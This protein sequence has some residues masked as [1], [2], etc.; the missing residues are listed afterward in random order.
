MPTK[1]SAVTSFKSLEQQVDDLR[2]KLKDD[3]GMDMDELCENLKCYPRTAHGLVQ[4]KGWAI[5]VFIR[6]RN[7][8]F[9]VNPKILKQHAHQVQK[10]QA[11]H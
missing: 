8:L 9:L 6:N 10:A 7:R 1:L 3:E 11:A 4:R 2:K 5:T